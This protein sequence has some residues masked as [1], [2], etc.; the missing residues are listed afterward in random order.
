MSEVWNRQ[1]VNAGQ[2]VFFG[3]NVGKSSDSPYGS[4]LFDYEVSNFVF[5]YCLLNLNHRYTMH[6][7]M[8]LHGYMCM[9]QRASAQDSVRAFMT[10]RMA[11][12]ASLSAPPPPSSHV[13]MCVHGWVCEHVYSCPC[14][15]LCHL[16]RYGSHTSMSS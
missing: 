5:C 13:C 10:L 14:M 15:C 1:C 9:Q 8:H 2:L 12:H 11:V 7:P 3:C 4:G 6:I 16:H